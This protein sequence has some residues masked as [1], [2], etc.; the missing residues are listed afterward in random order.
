MTPTTEV[1]PAAEVTPTEAVTPTSAET[2]TT[3]DEIEVAPTTIKTIVVRVRI[4]NVR[5][6][7][8][9]RYAVVGR[10]TYRKTAQVTGISANGLWYRVL[11]ADGSEGNCWVT[12]S[13]R[14]VIARK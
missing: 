13:S 4:L 10:L 9:T 8:G 11:C 1:A 12:A 5:S 7:P 2:A 3:S 6:G 14:Y